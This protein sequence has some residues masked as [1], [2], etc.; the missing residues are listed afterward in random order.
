LA[1]QAEPT[2]EIDIG[3]TDVEE[4]SSERPVNSA[5][6]LDL[7]RSAMSLFLQLWSWKIRLD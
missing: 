3:L 5:A 7:K 6:A 4:R 2:A 1:D